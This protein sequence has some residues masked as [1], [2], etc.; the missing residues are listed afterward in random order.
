MKS[1]A[2]RRIGRLES[3]E[4]VHL[5]S[6]VVRQQAGQTIAEAVGQHL[7]RFGWTHSRAP[8][9][10]VVPLPAQT[11]DEWLQQHAPFAP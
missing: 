6:R 8:A 7:R 4:R 9:L 1:P 10:A 5:M 3:R 11:A 2:I